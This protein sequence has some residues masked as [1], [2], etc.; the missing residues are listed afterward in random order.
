M[1]ISKSNLFIPTRIRKDSKL[2]MTTNDKV[3]RSTFPNFKKKKIK[4]T[5][6]KNKISYHLL[7]HHP[8][9]ASSSLSLYTSWFT[10]RNQ[11]KRSWTRRGQRC[12]RILSLTPHKP[13]QISHPSWK[14]FLTENT[15]TPG[16]SRQVFNP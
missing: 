8:S 16:S 6:P 9:F 2:S 7:L 15:R 11:L 14:Q 10:I 5:F 12:I 4:S 3:T 13:R 1:Q